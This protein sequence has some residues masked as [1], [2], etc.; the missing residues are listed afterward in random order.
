MSGKRTRFVTLS[1]R[2]ALG[3]LLA[4]AGS[5]ARGADAV[6][7]WNRLT[8]DA[9]RFSNTPPPAAARNLAIVH[10][11]VFDA[12][13]AIEKV[14]IGYRHHGDAPA[15]ASAEAAAAAA[16]NR[17]LRFLWPQ[18]TATFDAEL[19]AQLLA[20]PADSTR[21]LGVTWGR[22]VADDLLRER[23]L[24]GAN[25]G[26]DYRPA[27]GPGRWSP[28]PA[29]FASALLPQWPGVRPFA[30]T[31]GSQFRPPGPP[32]LDSQEWARQFREVKDLGSVNSTA[33]TPEQTTLAWFWADGQ[34]TQTPP[35]HWNDVA[36]QLAEGRQFPLIHT[37]RLLALLNL[38]MADAGIAAW[39]AKYTYEWWRPVTAIR[40]GNS[41]GNPATDPDP[42]WS[43]LIS[44]PPF[45]EHVSGHS[46]FS[47]AAAAVLA[48]VHGQDQFPFRLRSDGLFGAERSYEGFAAAAAESG[49]SRI[50]GGIHYRAADEGGQALGT[51]IGRWVVDNFLLPAASLRF[52]IERADSR[53]KIRW[54]SGCRVE[55]CRNLTDG[56]WVLVPGIGEWEI[57]PEESPMRFL[58]FGP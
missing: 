40:A 9:I 25:L 15:A 21:S 43:P 4:M 5:T 55:T 28:T 34:G 27:V 8:L 26:V 51:A 49:L 31:S 1:T 53:L 36:V 46:T 52:S 50:L 54:P 48:A 57:L 33:R 11:A 20:L 56:E 22:Q 17:A 29:L 42:A 58:R 12:I 13:N 39:D 3:L 35:G 45:P 38:A 23:D 44:T 2:L 37:A 7:R 14:C 18:F 16:A 30:L 41:D 6:V 47:A 10:L 24:D 32:P 19:T